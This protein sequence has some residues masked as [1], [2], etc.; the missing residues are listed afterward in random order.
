[1]FLLFLRVWPLYLALSFLFLSLCVSSFWNSHNIY[2]VNLKVFYKFLWLSSLF[3]ILSFCSSN[4]VVSNDLSLSVL[5]LSFAWSSWL[6]NL[7][8][9]FLNSVIVFAVQNLFSSFFLFYYYFFYCSGFCHTLKWN[10]HGFTCVPHPDPPSHLPLHPI[11]LGLP[12][13]PGPSACLLH[14][15][16]AGDLFHPR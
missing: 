8:S 2:T 11:L 7:S 4:S 1:M 13:A 9:E 14:P 10:S 5:I 3:L 12:S 16:W 6:V 15:T